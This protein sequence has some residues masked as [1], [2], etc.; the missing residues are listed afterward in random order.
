M[1]TILPFILVA[2]ML[3][4]VGALFAG[5]VSFAFNIGGN[6]QSTRLMSARVLLQGL[7]LAVFGLLA[8][9]SMH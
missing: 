4:T 2:V 1:Q 3:A 5:I 8:L 7:A 6:K 9:V